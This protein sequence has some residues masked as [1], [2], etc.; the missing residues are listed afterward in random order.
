MKPSGGQAVMAARKSPRSAVK[1]RK[2]KRASK[3]YEP[4]PEVELKESDPRDDLDFFP[5][6]PWATR[7]LLEHV[8]PELKDIAHLLGAWDPCCGEGHMTIP[9]AEYFAQVYA[10]D[11]YPHGFG[12]VGA[13]VAGGGLDLGDRAHCPFPPDWILFNPPFALAIEFVERALREATKGVA[14]LVR[15]G[16]L[17]SKERFDLF[18]RF[19][20]TRAG[21]FAERVP[22]VKH[23]WDP[24]ASSATSYTWFVWERRGGVFRP[25]GNGPPE[26]P[27]RII[28]PVCRDTL[29]FERDLVLARPEDHGLFEV[30]A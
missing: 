7:A 20:P 16:W 11:I 23:R 4:K 21:V 10:S 18:S 14:A 24:E 26:F 30:A 12:Q 5:T 9:L 17:E 3:H 1:A 27:T 13:F 22:M 19:E 29:M 2:A 8:I 28:P 15:T 6:P 25:A